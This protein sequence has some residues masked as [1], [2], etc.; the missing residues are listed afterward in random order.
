MIPGGGREGVS[1]FSD[2]MHYLCHALQLLCPVLPR[3]ETETAHKWPEASDKGK[4][5]PD[6]VPREAG[7]QGSDGGDPACTERPLL[8]AI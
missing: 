1:L 8:L 7:S 6:H 4:R 2:K 5:A 3:N